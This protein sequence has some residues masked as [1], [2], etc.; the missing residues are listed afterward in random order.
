MT[1]FLQAPVPQSRGRILPLLISWMKLQELL[2]TSATAAA[3]AN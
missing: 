2:A 3:K 1:T